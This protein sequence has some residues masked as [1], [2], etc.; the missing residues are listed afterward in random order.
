[1]SAPTDPHAQDECV[2]CTRRDQ[3]AVLF[4]TRSLYVMPDKFPA[5]PGHVLIIAK[6]HLA[7]YAAAPEVLP[8]LEEAKGRIE[9]FLRAAYPV[10]RELDGAVREER[11]TLVEPTIY[12]MEHGIYGQTVFHA[13]LHVAPSPHLPIPPEY[14]AHPDVQ[15]IHG[16]DP[17][18]TRFAERGQYRVLEYAGARYL[19]DGPSP[20]IALARPW[21]ARFT[22]MTWKPEGGW[23]KYTSDA[24]VRELERRWRVWERS[25]EAA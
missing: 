11:E 12:A 20:S 2:F 10:E 6:E 16:W 5:R 18:L 13:H 7:C 17:V 23:Q 21:F 25:P 24:D 9:Q 19:V 15:P 4:E 22:G 3:P 8:E 14:L 1:M